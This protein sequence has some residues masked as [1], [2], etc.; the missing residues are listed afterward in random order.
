MQGTQG[1]AFRGRR[2]GHAGDEGEVMQGTQGTQRLA[3]EWRAVLVTQ[4]GEKLL[5]LFI[6]LQER[7]RAHLGPEEAG[8]WE[9]VLPQ[10]VKELSKLKNS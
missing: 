8:A 4:L 7:I 2:G 9:L 6:R 3:S 5:P 10:V 1:K